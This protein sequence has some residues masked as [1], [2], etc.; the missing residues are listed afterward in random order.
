MYESGEDYLETILLLHRKTGYVRSIDIANELNYSK[1]S[2]SRAMNILKENG[3]ITVETGGRIALTQKGQAKAEA[4]Y[5]R[6]VTIT[7]FFEKLLGVSP[8]N[9]EHDACKI[10]HIISDESY[11]KLK[12]YMAKTLGT[13]DN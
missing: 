7:A 5:E 13:A 12:E 11:G 6:H 4:V 1:P 10:E 8:E 3:Y 9:A 2:I